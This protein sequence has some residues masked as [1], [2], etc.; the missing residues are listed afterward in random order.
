MNYGLSRYVLGSAAFV[1]ISEEEY[2]QIKLAQAN[3]FEMLF[4]E[5]KFDVVIENYLE[6][7]MSFLEIAAGHMVLQNLNYY[8]F[9][10]ERNSVN[11]R[12][13]NLL[14]ACRSYL[15]QTM[16]HL[17]NMFSK[18]SEIV[19]EIEEYKNQRY[20]QC[21]GYR[22]M[23]AL[24]NYVQH[25]GFPIHKVIFNRKLVELKSGNRMLFA[26]TPCI[27]PDKLEEDEQFKKSVLK[28][29]KASGDEID[30]KPLIRDYIASLGGV[31]EKIRNLLKADVHGWTQTI[32]TA[33]SRFQERYPKEPSIE[34]LEAVVRND[35]GTYSQRVPLFE[36]FIE[37]RQQ[38]ENKNSNL[39]T[40]G[41]R[42][43]SSEVIEP[44]S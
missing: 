15:D 19:K 18:E 24:R 40:L 34:G 6:L 1:D 43:V 11:R 35:D 9:Q 2:Q 23:E 13:V 25:R 10:N 3:L 32:L 7:E 26:L 8:R 29:L 21:L 4:I 36:D 14:S 28:E 44:T 41:K 17:H 20:D 27:R 37:Y 42:Y 16:H 38:L 39:A 22:V 31:H 5:T 12:L 30:I 33:M